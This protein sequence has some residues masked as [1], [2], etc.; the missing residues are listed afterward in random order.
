VALDHFRTLNKITVK[1]NS[2]EISLS[3]NVQLKGAS[4]VRMLDHHFKNC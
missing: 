2:V 3:Q 1:N 4:P